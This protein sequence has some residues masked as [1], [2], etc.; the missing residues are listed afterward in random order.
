LC[1][2]V[3]A[4][5]ASVVYYYDFGVVGVAGCG[6]EE[7]GDALGYG[8]FFVVGGDDKGD[9]GV[10]VAFFFFCLSAFPDPGGD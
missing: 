8:F 4:V 3:C 9:G 5:G 10:K 1:H 6:S 7:A 2:F